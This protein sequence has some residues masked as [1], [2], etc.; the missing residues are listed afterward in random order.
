MKAK[1]KITRRISLA[2]CITILVPFIIASAL[3]MTAFAS[4]VVQTDADES[5]ITQTVFFDLA[6]GLVTID[7]STYTGYVFETI[8]G[9]TT[10]KTVTG[11]HSVTTQYYVYQSTSVNRATTGLVG[12]SE[13]V[14]LPTYARMTCDGKSWGDYI[15]NNTNPTAVANNWTTSAQDVGKES[16][17]NY[18]SIT[19]GSTYNVV[20]DNLWSTE[21][22]GSQSRSTGGITFVPTSGGKANISLVGDSRFGNIH[23]QSGTLTNAEIT[24][25][26]GEKTTL[27]SMTVVSYDGKAN[28][29]NSVIG[30]N[31]DGTDNSRGI[32]INGGIIYAGARTDG[33]YTGS[34]QV[35]NCSAIGGGG[36]GTGVVTI[37]GG[38]V[39]AVTSS[40]GAAIGGGIGENSA[41]G[42]GNV[43][44]TGGEVYAYNFGY[45]TYSSVNPYTVPGAAIGGASSREQAGGLGTVTISGGKVY[46]YS[47]GGAAIGGGSSTKNYGGAADV[48]ISG[49][50]EVT[51]I[52]VAGTVNGQSVQAGVS[53]GGGTAGDLSETNNGG[54]ATLTVN[55]GKLFTGSIGGGACNN[56]NGSIGAATVT[57]NDGTLQ[58]QVIMQGINPTTKNPSSF[59]MTGGT[60]DNTSAHTGKFVFLED[61][62]GAVCVKS[63]TATIEGGIIKNCINNDHLGG[64]IY[65]SGGNVNMTGGT[66]QSCQAQKGGAVYI[67]GGNMTMSG[68]T[69]TQNTA[70]ENG[71]AVYI[72]AGSLSV[73]GSADISSN[74]AINGAGAYLAGGSMTVS[75]NAIIRANIASTDGGAA[76]LAG[77]FFTMSGGTMSGNT[78]LNGAGALVANGNVTVLGGLITQNTATVNGGAFCISNGNYTMTGGELTYNRALTGDGGAIYV[79]SSQASTDITIRSGSIIHNTA[80]KNGGALGVYGQ[81]GIDFVITIGSC[82]NHKDCDAGTHKLAGD[83]TKAET[84]PII[85]NNISQTSGGAIYLAGSYDAVM[86]MY[87]LVEK[88]NIVGD[89]VS[90][91]NF[92]MVDGG[93]LNI[94]SKGLN[95]ETDF[96]K[97]EINSSIHVSGGRVTLSGARDNPIFNDHV[98]VD[99][100][101]GEGDIDGDFFMDLRDGGTGRVILY[102]ENTPGSSRYVLIDEANPTSHTVLPNMYVRPG[103]DMCGWKLEKTGAIYSGGIVIDDTGNLIFHA[104]WEMLQYTIEFLPG[105]DDFDGPYDDRYQYFEYGKEQNLALNRYTVYAYKFVKWH[106]VDAPAGTSDEDTIFTDGQAFTWPENSEITKITLVAEWIICNHEGTKYTFTVTQSSAERVCNCQAYTESLLLE[107]VN[108]V[109]KE[110]TKHIV[111]PNHQSI[112]Q[113]IYKPVGLWNGVTVKYS[114]TPNDKSTYGPTFEAPENAGKYTVSLEITYD[115]VTYTLSVDLF[116]DRAQRTQ[117]PATPQYEVTVDI[118]GEGD[119]D[120]V[121]I[122]KITDA[123]SDI[124]TEYLFSWYQDGVLQTSE[125]IKWSSSPTQEL[126]VAWTNYYVDVRYAET[127]NYYASQAIRGTKTVVWTADVTIIIRTDTEPGLNYS[128]VD[129]YEQ[130][131]NKEGIFVT[132]IP[133]SGYYIYNVDKTVTVKPKDKDSNNDISEYPLPTFVSTDISGEEWTVQIRNIAEGTSY[134][135]LIIEVSFTGAAKKVIVDSSVVKNEEFENVIAKGENEVKISRDSAYTVCFDVKNYEHYSEPAI[136][137]GTAVPV[138]TT[139]IMVDYT[140]LSY[141]RYTVATAVDQVLLGDFI[142]MGTQSTKFSCDG[143]Q[144][145]TLQ[146]VVDFSDCATR[147]EN[148]TLS[149]SFVATPV[150]PDAL[151][152]I[153]SGVSVDSKIRNVPNVAIVEEIQFV[154]TP[155]F[156]IGTPSGTGLTQSLSYQFA[157]SP[158]EGAGLSKWDNTCGI[159]VITPKNPAALP[160]DARLQVRIGNSIKTYSL[161]DKK[162]TVALLSSGEGEVTITLLSGM[163]PNQNATFVFDVQLYAS[164]TAVKIT[165]KEELLAQTS[166]TYTVTQ[167][168]KPVVHVSFDGKLPQY[169]GIDEAGKGMFTSFNFN[170]SLREALPNGWSI[171]ADLYAKNSNGGYTN[172]TQEGKLTMITATQYDGTVKFDSFEQQMAQNKGSLSLMIKIEILDQT[173]QVLNSVPLYFVLVDTRQ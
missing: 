58:G 61:N 144:N 153:A 21:N 122:I 78:A 151:F 96:G 139:I 53:I 155:T 142:R 165:P 108:T 91:S 47:V 7:E 57:I 118:K 94:T 119:E 46:A 129:P 23:Y 88:D 113:N 138:G 4:E 15:T 163:L 22:D 6:A 132:L 170:I 133:T 11:T 32:V 107:A 128:R 30:D 39:T 104:T 56:G 37:N 162:F 24:F 124:E 77:G 67:D 143:K 109:Y 27:A 102:Y 86:N 3:L 76:Y 135:G 154:D 10:T 80:G 17:G 16:T 125:W 74:K 26:N 20:I 101:Q 99:V 54:V 105:V 157:Y 43:T 40:T 110:G 8:D 48:T 171:R 137:F 13:T 18:I 121:N 25:S 36:N 160:A 93:T 112:S 71:G 9:T 148:V 131:G 158:I 63:G 29:Y 152:D 73:S 172:T 69:L 111:T 79:S 159:L 84:C 168:L 116:I 59:K 134:G 87:C 146:F 127:P 55:G 147:I 49:T 12:D 1:L 19:G 169:L 98:T 81:N 103:Y 149:T 35:D 114:G 68:G 140:D 89:G 14:I 70:I 106:W 5:T 41:G 97:M 31:D 64:A 150:Y 126:S 45:L 51:A 173:G 141:W 136:L 38:K 166:L 60:I 42:P 50:A 33:K 44:I 164:A 34:F 100:T 65:L 117:T 90:T 145:F 161:I 83:D 85:Q 95:G 66:I 82:T 120:D 28:H 167:A 156:E 130:N 52:S 75:G 2:L 115:S 92:M 72:N 62:G 123:K